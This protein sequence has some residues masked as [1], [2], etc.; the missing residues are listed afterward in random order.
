M[1]L[2]SVSRNFVLFGGGA[3]VF[4][5]RSKIKGVHTY[6]FELGKFYCFFSEPI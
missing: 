3:L 1:I 5:I 6:Y 4:V 2:D